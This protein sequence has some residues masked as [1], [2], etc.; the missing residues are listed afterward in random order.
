MMDNPPSSGDL[1]P[2]IL[3]VFPPSP[4]KYDFSYHLGAGYVR[5]YLQQHH[6]ES[7]QFITTREKSIPE[8]VHD[9][10]S[11]K[12]DIIGFTCY[13]AN[14]P[15][16]R[17][18]AQCLKKKDPHIKIVLGGP[19]ATF[20]PRIIM[21]HT[22]EIDLCIRGEGEKT[23]VDLIQKGF[24]NMEDIQGITFRSPTITSTPSRPLI[25]S[26]MKG[27][28]LDVLPSPYLTGFIPPDGKT[29]VLTGRGCVYHCTYCNF[30]TMFNHTIRYHSVDRVTAEL[31]LINTHWDP[32]SKEKIM[33]QDDIFSLNLKRAKTI[34]QQI[35]DKGICLPLSVE[36]RADNCDE[37]LIQLMK[38]AGVI[39]INF[40]LESASHN[41]LKTIKKAPDEK[42]FL[43]QI[44][45]AVHW[46]QKAGIKTS[47]S[48]ILGLPKETYKEAQ[49]TLEFVRKLHVDEYYHNVLF[50]FPGTELFRTRKKYGLDVEHSPTFLPYKTI[51]AYDVQ[52]VTPLPHAGMHKQIT[53]WKKT[54]CDVLTYQSGDVYT[55]FFIKG[56][57][58]DMHNLCTFLHKV[59]ALHLSVVDATDTTER[60][61][62]RRIKSMVERG[63]PVGFYSMVNGVPR[64]RFLEL[65]SQA[66]LKTPVP[67]IPFCEW[68][69]GV[70]ELVT[71]E[72]V[73]DVEKC[74][75]F[76]Q[77]HI[78]DGILSC[79]S[80]E[81]PSMVVDA[82]KWGSSMCPAL[83]RGFLVVD[84]NNMLS[85][86]RG[87]CIGKVGDDLD[88]LQNNIK[89]LQTQKEKER[90]CHT[91]DMRNECSRC[92]FPYSLTDEQFCHLKRKY[93]GI[94][95]VIPL[96]RWLY[97]YAG[98]NDVFIKFRMDEK[99]P[100][101]FYHGELVRGESLPEVADTVTLI[102][103]EGNAFAC[104]GPKSFSLDPVKAAILEACQLRVGKNELL[105]Y[106]GEKDDSQ[107]ID[108]VFFIFRELGLLKQK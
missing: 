98:K 4:R 47:V 85:C 75:Q 57:P 51:Y 80:R 28:E 20:S 38:E 89:E 74:A 73:E 49:K 14:Y 1:I 78:K 65:Y 30:S 42:K 60:E 7:A 83:S 59:S 84:G 24:E 69:E 27:A 45:N 99:A 91:C 18:L 76:L 12:S 106:L 21:E 26:T 36:T 31:E 100:P 43:G 103:C 58:E 16:I 77:E 33:I 79:S 66:A 39:W 53:L 6:I 32:R 102:S 61:I 48:V 108:D 81:L 3:F 55:Y 96:L 46:A 2:E 8:I 104:S 40:G 90:G 88:V 29:G 44:K 37:E 25:T 107:F 67:E 50:L 62:E 70:N 82:C 5:S 54:Y 68:E 34:C 19:T 35:I 41:V 9:I 10:L 52:Q 23:M 71:M 72:R 13:D 92:L 94:S 63:V 56:M 86:Y 87:G 101:L 17:I 95:K 105:D 22:P 93:P 15:Y 11:Y 97:M 64:E